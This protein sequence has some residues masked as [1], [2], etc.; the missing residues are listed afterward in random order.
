MNFLMISTILKINKYHFPI[1]ILL[2]LL[3]IANSNY[4]SD[5]I[6]YLQYLISNYL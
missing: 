3:K 1:T 2:S 4:T 5:I 6:T